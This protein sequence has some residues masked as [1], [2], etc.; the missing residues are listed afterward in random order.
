ME[1]WKRDRP[2]IQDGRTGLFSEQWVFLSLEFQKKLIA[3][4]E[5]QAKIQEDIL[6][7]AKSSLSGHWALWENREID[8]GCHVRSGVRE[9]KWTI[10]IMELATR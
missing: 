4:E 3:I 10:P 1:S 5:K 7:L 6:I 9:E 2:H 8:Q